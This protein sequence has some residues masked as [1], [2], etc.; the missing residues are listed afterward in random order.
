MRRKDREMSQEFALT[1]IDKSVFG[2]LSLVDDGGEPYGI[3]LSLVRDGNTLYFHAAKEGRKVE[4]LAKNPQVS[5]SFVGETKVPEI[6][7]HEELE[8]IVQDQQKAGVLISKVFTTEFESAIVTGK[9]RLLED[10]QE[11]TRALRL[12]CEK[13]TPTKMAYFPIAVEAG[14]K[15]TNVYAIDIET[16]TAKRKKYNAHGEELKRDPVALS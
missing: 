16:I 10:D 4:L 7:S 13:Y 14:L 3:P 15:R 6:Y 11:K 8:Q 2:V 12:I 5:V 9:V 1:V